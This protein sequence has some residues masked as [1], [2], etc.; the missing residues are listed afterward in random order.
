MNYSEL[1]Q[2]VK[3]EGAVFV[4]SNDLNSRYFV[5]S[6]AGESGIYLLVNDKALGDWE[7]VYRRTAEGV[8]DFINEL[9]NGEGQD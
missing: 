8:G 9:L 1:K 7:I 3:K 5:E 6:W 2:D 4:R